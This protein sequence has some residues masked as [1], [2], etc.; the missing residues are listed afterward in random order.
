MVDVN[1]IIKAVTTREA[2]KPQ[3]FISKNVYES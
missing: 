2:T 1:D 3:M